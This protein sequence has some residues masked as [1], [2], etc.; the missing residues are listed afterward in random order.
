MMTSVY[1]YR[2][3]R[4]E[5]GQP[6]DGN[7]VIVKEGYDLDGDEYLKEA[8]EVYAEE[9]EK[10]KYVYDIEPIEYFTSEWT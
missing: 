4:Y 6:L 1:Y 8:V 7:S 3:R 2:I 5:V 10:G 9:A